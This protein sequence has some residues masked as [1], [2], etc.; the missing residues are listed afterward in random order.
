MKNKAFDNHVKKQFDG[1]RPGV[2]E[3]IWEKIEAERKKKKPV[4]VWLTVILNNKIA[5]SVVLLLCSAAAIWFA[6][7]NK[8]TNP[9]VIFS[10][11]NT[12]NNTEIQKQDAQGSS[13]N[14]QNLTVIQSTDNAAQVP[15][16]NQFQPVISGSANTI[17]NNSSFTRPL[18]TLPEYLI[19][20]GQGDASK[21]NKRWNTYYFSPETLPGREQYSAAT[22]MMPSLIKNRNIPCP[23]I[24]KDAAANKKYFELYAGPDYAFKS[25]A[26]TLNSAYLPQRKSSTS[27]KFAYSAGLRYTRVFKNGMSLRTGINYSQVNEDFKYSK[28]NVIHN[29][30]ITNSAGDTTGSYTETGTQYQRNTNKRRTIDVPL[31][32][33]Y[34]MGNG[35]IHANVY[36]GAVVNIHSSQS[37]FVVDPAGNAVNISGKNN[38][39]VYS[40]RTNTGVS[41]T[42]GVSLYYKLNEQLQVVAEPYIRYALSPVTKSDITFKEKYHA[43]GIRMGVRMD[44]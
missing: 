1:Y 21:L 24:E 16:N 12:L 37:G 40:Y 38:T 4:P 26:D 30:F 14:L 41:F 19:V 5:A 33:G 44:L 20:N 13:G 28:G 7:V 15:A 8:N 31:L 23:Q 42:A 22:L 18:N 27:T 17:L 36:A 25:F 29:V 35:K 43:A 3:H 39:S 34:E 32:A 2:P 10:K 11:N 6:A 9:V